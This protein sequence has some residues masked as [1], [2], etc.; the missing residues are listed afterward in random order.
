M[1]RGLMKEHASL[2]GWALHVVDWLAISV[3]GWLAYLTYLANPQYSTPY[4]GVAFFDTNYP[5]VVG[6]GMILSAWL[7]PRFHIYQ[8]W[9][10]GSLFEEIRALS[11]GWFTVLLFL[12]LFAFATKTGAEFSRVWIFLWGGLCWTA[13]V[14]SRIVLRLLLRTLRSKGFNLRQIVVVGATELGNELIDRAKRSP[15]MG[16]EVLGV[17]SRTGRE[18]ELGAIKVEGIKLLGGIEDVSVY[19]DSKDVDQVWITLALKD[20]DLISELLHDLRHSTVD[21]RFVPNIFEFRLLN[22]SMMEVGGLPVINLSVSPM[23][24]ANRMIKAIEDRV[25]SSIILVLTMPLMIMVALII[26]L[27]SPGPVF[28]RQERIGWSGK[29]FMMLKFRTMPVGAEKESGP[30]WARADEKRATRFG[31]FLRSTSLDELPQFI[32]VLKGDMSIVG[33]R[34]ERPVFVDKFKDEVPGYMQ[35]HLVKAGITGWA[36]VNGWR[37]DTDLRKRIEYDLFYIENWSLWF[38]LRIMFLTLFKGFI[39]KH[40]Y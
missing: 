35:K 18:E 38:D 12:V 7:F 24:G 5:I 6:V 32:N 13:L 4:L 10:G 36:Q 29:P 3:T 14:S 17:F 26:K 1:N 8:V 37:G 31:A 19:V 2:W 25:L 27:T 11:L 28:F 16:L 9:R 39:S 23:D 30:V 22:H 33:P 40:A 34:P 20:E 15:W 21:I